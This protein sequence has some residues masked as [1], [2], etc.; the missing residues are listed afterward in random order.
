[1]P[2]LSLCAFTASSRVNYRSEGHLLLNLNLIEA[3]GKVTQ[4]R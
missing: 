1:M 2:L 4:V 3:C